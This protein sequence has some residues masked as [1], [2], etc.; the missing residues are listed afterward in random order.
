MPYHVSKGK[1]ASLVE[2]ALADLPEPFAQY[3]EEV[4]VDVRERPTLKQL[5]SV[6][7][8]EDDLLMGLYVGIPLTEKSVLHSGQAPGVIYI[9]QEDIELV[10]DS[11]EELVREVRVTVLHELGH[12]FGLDEDDLARLGY[13]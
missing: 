7:L 13:G 8:A 9:F 6:G 10:C 3:I 11:A 4:P 1:F 12:H 2:E 5:K